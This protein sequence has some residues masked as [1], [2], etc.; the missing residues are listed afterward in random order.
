[1][2]KLSYA[3]E[4][5]VLEETLAALQARADVV[6]QLA[7]EVGEEL[8]AQIAEIKAL[9]ERQRFYA[10]EGMAA[11]E[12]MQAVIARGMVA[13]RDI[14]GCAVLLY[15]PKNARLT[16]FGIRIR[17]RPRRKAAT[18]PEVMEKASGAA[19][20]EAWTAHAARANVAAVGGTGQ[21]IGASVGEIRGEAGW[22]GG[23]GPEIGGNAP[24]VGAPVR[25][26]GAVPAYVGATAS[27]E[28]GNAQNLGANLPTDQ[29]A[30]IRAA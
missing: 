12:T 29:R 19:R 6:P 28:R 17:R 2:P 5:A 14:R 3:E 24:D 22:I 13:A 16:Q 8:A 15:G 21:E 25:P 23:S 7:L 9:R 4:V 27:G 1:M 18:P 26:V 11:T 30:A 10:A 20:D